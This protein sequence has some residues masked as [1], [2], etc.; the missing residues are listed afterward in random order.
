[1][2][3]LIL[4]CCML[5]ALQVVENVL[6]ECGQDIDAA[7]RRLTQ[8]KLNA[9]HGSATQQ[10]AAQPDTAAAAD[11]PQRQEHAQHAAAAA[12]AASGPQTADQWVDALVQ[13]MATAK[14]IPDA[15]SRAGK[16]LQAFEQFTTT[17]SKA[18]VGFACWLACVVGSGLLRRSAARSLCTSGGGRQSTTLR[19]L[20]SRNNSA[21][22]NSGGGESAVQSCTDLLLLLTVLYSFP[23][24][25]PAATT[26]VCAAQ[27]RL[28]QVTQENAILKRAVQIQNA[29]L[30]EASAKDEEIAGLKQMLGQYQERLR[31]MELNNYS[32]ALHLQKATND[33]FQT[34]NRPPDVF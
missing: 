19:S 30:Q 6:A 18:E 7:I 21:G 3:V 8:L 2:H 25:F 29:K 32:L 15:R 4:A 12:A 34:P 14:D 16:L 10:A 27:A 31:Q 13:E 33:S 24:L 22:S 23:A 17:R 28:E 26:T 11:T 5:L 20:H 9:E 1:M